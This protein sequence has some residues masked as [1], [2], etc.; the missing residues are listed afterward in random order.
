M[1]TRV[2]NIDTG[3][4]EASMD[5]A[6]VDSRAA[7]MDP[8]LSVAIPPEQDLA[9]LGR[10]SRYEIVYVVWNGDE[11]E[12]VILPDSTILCD[13][14][15]ARMTRILDGLLVYPERM[16]QNMAITRGLIFSPPR[17]MI[18][19]SRPVRLRYPSLS[20]DP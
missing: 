14:M 10:R 3:E 7:L 18:S 20:N 5:P 9:R 16:A 11:V 15:L 13:Y 2:L 6:E 8:E 17:L 19:L 4:F 12:R 1:D